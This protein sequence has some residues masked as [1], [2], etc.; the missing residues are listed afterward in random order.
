[1]AKSKRQQQ[2]RTAYSKLASSVRARAKMLQK[3]YGKW[4]KPANEAMA[5]AK[6]LKALGNDVSTKD[7]K[8]AMKQLQ[9]LRP[10]MYKRDI[11]KRLAETIE[12]LHNPKTPGASRY[13]NIDRSNIV[14]FLGM[15][16][17]IYYKS[18]AHIYGSPEVAQQIN[19]IAGSRKPMTDEQLLLNMQAWSEYI[20]EKKEQAAD[21][22]EDFIPPKLN[23]RRKPGKKKKSGSK[24]YG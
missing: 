17:D 20:D 19:K 7:L 13:E 10:A 23:L 2:I 4:L 18:L 12:Q 5:M 3:E 15:M 11:E 24:N 1:M 9:R 21:T 6:P 22:G 8:R 14:E 16:E